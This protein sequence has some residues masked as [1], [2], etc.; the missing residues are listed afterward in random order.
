MMSTVRK[1]DDRLVDAATYL[2]SLTSREPLVRCDEPNRNL[3]GLLNSRTGYRILVD[4]R[5]LAQ[6]RRAATFH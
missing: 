3:V 6:F 4:S 2:A 5:D 1:S